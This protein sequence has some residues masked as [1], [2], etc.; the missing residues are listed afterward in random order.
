VQKSQ[1]DTTNTAPRLQSVGVHLMRRRNVPSNV[2]LTREGYKHYDLS[3]LRIQASI[4][5]H[6]VERG[7]EQSK[8]TCTNRIHII[9]KS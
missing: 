3:L 7:L 6:Y 2:T 5:T 9:L 8:K 1:I 4:V